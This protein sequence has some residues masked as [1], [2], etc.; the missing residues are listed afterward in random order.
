MYWA[1][2]GDTVTHVRQLPFT[3]SIGATIYF[4]NPRYSVGNIKIE[5]SN[6]T[7]SPTNRYRYIMIPGGV[8]GGRSSIDFSNYR[9]VLE[10][11]GIPE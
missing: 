3:E 2:L 8:L 10:K 6:L 11:L 9:E 5:T 4:H 7:M 1:G